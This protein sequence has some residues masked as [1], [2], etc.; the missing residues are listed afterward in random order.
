LLWEVLF[1][2]LLAGEKERRKKENDGDAGE[3]PHGR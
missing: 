1:G 3:C 2:D